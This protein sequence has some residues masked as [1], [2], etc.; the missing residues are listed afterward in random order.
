MNYTFE[1][2]FIPQ[3]VA[4]SNNDDFD[5][6]SVEIFDDFEFIEGCFEEKFPKEANRFDWKNFSLCKEMNCKLTYWL[7]RFPE[8]QKD[9]EAKW[10]IILKK[11]NKP[12]SY[13]ILEK[14]ESDKLAL[15]S[16]NND[17][18]SCHKMLDGDISVEKFIE[19]ALDVYIL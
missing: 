8:P 18:R 11:D 17:V 5:I 15:C 6:D 3:I 16:F 19:E 13:F 7:L 4:N 1:Y 10:G 2:L 9:N 14:S 12:F